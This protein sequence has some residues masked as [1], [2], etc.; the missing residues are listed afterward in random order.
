M[1]SKRV[2]HISHKPKMVSFGCFKLIYL[3]GQLAPSKE[4]KGGISRGTRAAHKY[5]VD[6]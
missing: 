6:L 5:R 2:L 4:T 3:G 1:T